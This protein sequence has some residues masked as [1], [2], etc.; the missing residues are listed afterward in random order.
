MLKLIFALVDGYEG[1]A[2]AKECEWAWIFS[3]VG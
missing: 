3:W 1:V 2:Y